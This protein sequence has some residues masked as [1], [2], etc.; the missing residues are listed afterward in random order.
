MSPEV[1]R[2]PANG[3]HFRARK[4]L[5]RSA[6]RRAA[7]AATPPSRATTPP[8]A[9][10][11]AGWPTPRIFWRIF[12]GAL[13][14]YVGG[15]HAA[16]GAGKA[17]GYLIA[18]IKDVGEA[19]LYGGQ[20]R[21]IT[22]QPDRAALATHRLMLTDIAYSLGQDN[23]PLKGGE[24]RSADAEVRVDSDGAFR[25][26][27]D[28]ARAQVRNYDGTI[29]SSV[30]TP[31]RAQDIGVVRDGPGE[32]D[33][34]VYFST[35]RGAASA[36][37]SAQA[38]GEV[39]PPG[40]FDWRDAVIYFVFVDRFVHQQNAA[41]HTHLGFEILRWQ[42]SLKATSLIRGGHRSP[43]V[44]QAAGVPKQQ[45]RAVALRC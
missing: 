17:A 1:S 44:R 38:A 7:R 45:R 24:Y 39:P 21:E 16:T 30:R 31:L 25:T 12:G 6:T 8:V 41:Q 43:P 32:P 29:I 34:Y 13:A 9:A 23:Y 27:D 20:K 28:V 26:V 11:P 42:L 33:N 14:T 18:G 22:V 10:I 3:C 36:A 40:V 19:R 35:G 4:P 37:E 2:V 5:S 15:G